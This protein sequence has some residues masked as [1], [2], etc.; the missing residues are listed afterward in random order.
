[1]IMGRGI[2]IRFK[3]L[4]AM[5]IISVFAVSG[6]PVLSQETEGEGESILIE[7]TIVGDVDPA[8]AVT[9]EDLTI[10]IDELKLLVKPLTLEELQTE[11]AAWLLLLK[12]KVQEISKTEIANK[13]QSELIQ[14]E[15]DA[16][17]AIEEAKSKLEEAEAALDKASPGTAEYEKAAK[18]LE[19][20][21]QVFREAEQAIEEAVETGKELKEDEDIKEAL[22]E[23]KSEKQINLERQI[24]EEA[25]KERDKLLAGSAPYDEATKQIDT[26]EQALLD[27]EKAQ[28]DLEGAIPD[29]EEYKELSKQVEQLRAKVIQAAEEISKAGLAPSVEKDKVSEKPQDPK[30]ELEETVKN[31]E[32]SEKQLEETSENLEESEADKKLKESEKQLEETAEKLEK[33]AEEESDIRKQ[34]VVNVTEL[35]G[36]QTAIVDRFD[37]VLDALDKKGGD[38]TSYRKYIDAVSG[39]ELDVT[40]T[41][42]LG[43]RLVSW[44]KS[45][46]GGV[47]WGINL[48]KFLAI[49]VASMIVSNL[50]GK[51][52]HR[53]LGQVGG[54]SS[55]FRDFVVM[56]VKRG[57]LVVGVLFALTSLGISLGPILALVG[58]A[59]FV[60]AFAL[61]SNLGHFASGLMLLINKPFDV[62]DEV[63][64]AGY[65]AYVDSISL[66]NTRLK[67]F[68]GNI[69]NLPNS[70]VW[71]GDI[72]NYTH[73]EIRKFS[74]PIHVKFTQDVNEVYEM[75]M[76]IAKSHPKVLDTPKP[77]WF[78]WNKY[79][80]YYI[81]IN[82][83][84]WS[85]TEDYWTVYVELLKTLQKRIQ[86]LDIELTAPQQDI[87]FH[88]ASGEMQSAQLPPSGTQEQMLKG[89]E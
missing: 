36:D 29:S 33:V 59:S 46:E 45:E 49:L 42:G 8:A 63:R 68:S 53:V 74:F 89:E 79:Y 72:I 16:T 3:A 88:Q 7:S 11:A 82:L 51:F 76:E 86:E 58:G 73:A 32:E 10:P 21:K 2:V 62:G 75:W 50:L 64:V 54:T 48:A 56:M 37:V 85:R 81:Y 30:E 52:V 26:L 19:E 4:L 66:A 25:K 34:L 20:A 40:D 67:D 28:K 77:S 83:S 35:Q 15:E 87:N 27:L 70:T 60:L 18:Q 84:A 38:T 12:D 57:V 9:V 80:D 65:W 14:K 69:I 44:I 43:V 78:P 6:L 39:I 61:Q 55:L 41:E 71:E 31:L 22:E 23:A 47:R 24:L 1:M 17:K 5:G 13:R